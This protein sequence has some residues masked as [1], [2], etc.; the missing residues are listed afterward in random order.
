MDEL[1][2]LKSIYPRSTSTNINWTHIRSPTSMPSNPC[3]SLPSIVDLQ[4]VGQ[5]EDVGDAVFEEGHV[6][7]GRLALHAVLKRY[8]TVLNWYAQRPGDVLDHGDA[9]H[10]D[11]VL[12]D[13]VQHQHVGRIAHVVVG[14]DHQHV[15]V[16][17]GLRGVQV[18]GC[19]PLIRRRRGGQVV[20]VVVFSSVRDLF[21]S[22]FTM[23][24]EGNKHGNALIPFVDPD[25]IISAVN[26]IAFTKK[27]REFYF[28][29]GETLMIDRVPMPQPA[30]L[31]PPK[32]TNPTKQY[33]P[34]FQPSSPIK[35]AP[36]LWKK[37]FK[38]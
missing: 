5:L 17:P 25:R 35:Q 8:G 14:L 27:E 34:R 7:H 36:Q 28:S 4:L 2:F 23:D 20:A 6:L 9:D 18:L 30:P 38:K 12:G 21:P 1:T 32:I 29:S 3:T 26:E 19:L 13:L 15:R 37:V 11:H 31:E 24:Y 16:H 22:T 10:A 33:N